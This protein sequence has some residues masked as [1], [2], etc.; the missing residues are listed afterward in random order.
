M[1][2]EKNNPMAAYN[3]GLIHLF[4]GNK[5]TALEYMIEAEQAGGDVFEVVF[6]TGK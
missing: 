4:M 5:E 1:E 6:Q 3:V 2:L